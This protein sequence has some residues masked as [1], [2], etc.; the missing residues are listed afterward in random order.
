MVLIISKSS[1]LSGQYAGSYSV[2]LQIK[3][4]VEIEGHA[5]TQMDCSSIS[6]EISFHGL[7]SKTKRPSI[8]KQIALSLISQLTVLLVLRNS[9]LQRD[10]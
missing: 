2:F 8:R 1:Y 6:S 9:H 3:T 7:P 4:L 5:A 10:I